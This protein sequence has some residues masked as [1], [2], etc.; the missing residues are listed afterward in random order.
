MNN[1][2]I[3]NLVYIII[4]L[5]MKM[6]NNFVLLYIIIKNDNIYNYIWSKYFKY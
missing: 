2:I 5:K 4:I 6:Y 3:I 1:N